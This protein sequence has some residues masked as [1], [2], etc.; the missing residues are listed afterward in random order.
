M[1]VSLQRVLKIGLLFS[2]TS[3]HTGSG[4]YLGLCLLRQLATF[5]GSTSASFGE[6]KFFATKILKLSLQRS[7]TI[8][9]WI[10]VWLV[11][12]WTGLD[13]TKQENILLLFATKDHKPRKYLSC[14]FCCL[15]YYWFISAIS[16]TQSIYLYVYLSLY[17]S[18]CQSIS[19]CQSIN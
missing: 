9:G 17:I 1:T 8:G 13:L 19:I 6:F 4:R 14:C 2:L 16:I 11:S 10:P 12:N 18:M 7:L 15:Y 3:V 5:Q